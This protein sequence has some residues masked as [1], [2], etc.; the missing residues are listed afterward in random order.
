M[1]SMESLFTTFTWSLDT[2]TYKSAHLEWA[3]LQIKALESFL[4]E[5]QGHS[6]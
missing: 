6:S 5:I 3:P 2:L 1:D 4:F